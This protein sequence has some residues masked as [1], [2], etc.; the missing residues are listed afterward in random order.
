MKETN[1]WYEF[2]LFGM[3]ERDYSFQK[4]TV[5]EIKN[6]IALRV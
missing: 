1:H 4:N 2:E 3:W 6:S 5:M